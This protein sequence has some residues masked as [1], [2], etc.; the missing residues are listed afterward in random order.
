LTDDAEKL[1]TAFQNAEAD[2]S[3]FMQKLTD[4]L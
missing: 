2:H 4:G 1:I 3:V